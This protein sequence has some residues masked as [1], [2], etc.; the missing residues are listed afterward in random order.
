MNSAK[1]RTGKSPRRRGQILA[2]AALRGSHE[3]PV[4]RVDRPRLVEVGAIALVARA[5]RSFTDRDH[6]R[7][8]ERRVGRVD[9]AAAIEIERAASR[10]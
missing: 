2:N 7:F 4:G 10:T 5:S 6:A 3:R 1:H 9:G 8:E